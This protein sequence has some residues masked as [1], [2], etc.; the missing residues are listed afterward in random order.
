MKTV[1]SSPELL[2]ISFP[3]EGEREEGDQYP[4]I[5]IDFE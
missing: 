2:P 4:T 5:I 3:R 1:H